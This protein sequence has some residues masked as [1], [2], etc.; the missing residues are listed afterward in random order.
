MRPASPI[1]FNN[2]QATLV[3]ILSSE[4]P[5]LAA[6]LPIL[7][8]VRFSVETT[9]SLSP[10]R[11]EKEAVITPVASAYFDNGTSKEIGFNLNIYAGN[12]DDLLELGNALETVINSIRGGGVRY[13]S[14]DMGAIQV[15]EDDETNFHALLT[16]TAVFAGK[17]LRL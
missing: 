16:F 14:V 1:L 13:C 3:A 11:A 7:D 4:S 8:G 2:A 10:N 9:N 6:Y 17:S 5:K 15:P 12:F